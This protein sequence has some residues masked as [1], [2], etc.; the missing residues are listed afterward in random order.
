MQRWSLIGWSP[1]G[2]AEKKGTDGGNR[3]AT[4]TTVIVTIILI[5]AVALLGVFG[6]VLGSL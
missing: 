1:T 5:V 4:I 6:R 3:A 2:N